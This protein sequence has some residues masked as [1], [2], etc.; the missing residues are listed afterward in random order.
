ME[1]FIMSSEFLKSKGSKDQSLY[2]AHLPQDLLILTPPKGQ[3]LLMDHPPQRRPFKGTLPSEA[4]MTHSP[5]TAHSQQGQTH[6]WMK[7][8]PGCS[9][10]IPASPEPALQAQALRAWFGLSFSCSGSLLK[11]L[12]PYGN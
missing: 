9:N 10:T 4:A 7:A 11:P 8:Q 1:Y 2:K 5:G 6:E 12:S 3:S